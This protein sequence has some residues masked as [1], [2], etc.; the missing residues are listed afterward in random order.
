MRQ[1]YTLGT[2]MG[3]ICGVSA[4]AVEANGEWRHCTPD[5]VNAWPPSTRKSATIMNLATIS[6]LVLRG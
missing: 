1:K 3:I 4:R 2:P 5:G 6:C